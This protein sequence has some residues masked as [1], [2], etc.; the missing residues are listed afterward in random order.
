VK[1]TFAL[2]PLLFSLACSSAP[3]NAAQ[4]HYP[5]TGK[6]VSVDPKDQT[7]SINA[8]AIPGYMEAMTMDYPIESKNELA[9][10]HPGDHIT[11]TI[12]VNEDGTYLL[13]HIKVQPAPAE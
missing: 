3:K 13:S 10:L 9:S 12:D 7:A 1:V 2:I 5:L 8:A 4:K 11:A 6:V